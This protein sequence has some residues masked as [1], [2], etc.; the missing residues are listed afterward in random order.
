MHST[1]MFS[2]LFTVV[3]EIAEEKETETV[4]SQYRN[5]EMYI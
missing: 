1:D 2:G 5:L 3:S 4:K